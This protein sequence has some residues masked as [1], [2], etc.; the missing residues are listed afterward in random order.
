M[1]ADTERSLVPEIRRTPGCHGLRGRTTA[2]GQP[3]W[4]S[5]TPESIGLLVFLWAAP[6]SILTAQIPHSGVPGVAV[7][8]RWGYV[9]IGG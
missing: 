8:E 6:S 5:K 9:H 1:T 4:D 2:I 7:P 3:G